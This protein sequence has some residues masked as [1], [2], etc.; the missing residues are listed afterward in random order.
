MEEFPFWWGFEI[1]LSPRNN[2]IGRKKEI[3]K[4][5]QQTQGPLCGSGKVEQIFGDLQVDLWNWAIS[6]VAIP[7]PLTFHVSSGHRDCVSCPMSA[8]SHGRPG[9]LP[10]Y[11]NSNL[12][13]IFLHFRSNFKTQED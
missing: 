12:A 5:K 8:S 2:E 13:L 6:S 1:L 4:M 7:S 3:R 10:V 11:L 9:M